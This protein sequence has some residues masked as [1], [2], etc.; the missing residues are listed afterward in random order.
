MLREQPVSA[1][2]GSLDTVSAIRIRNNS[3]HCKN[4]RDMPIVSYLVSSATSWLDALR[5]I[6][7]FTCRNLTSDVPRAAVRHES[8]KSA[9]SQGKP[10]LKQNVSPVCCHFTGWLTERVARAGRDSTLPPCNF[11]RRTSKMPRFS[12]V[13]KERKKETFF[14]NLCWIP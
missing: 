13:R 10:Q 8:S 12:K 1:C 6:I 11:S 9:W 5:M 14:M 3:D 4:Q 7:Y 2:S